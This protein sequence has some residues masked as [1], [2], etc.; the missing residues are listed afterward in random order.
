MTAA[1]TWMTMVALMEEV[2]FSFLHS[3]MSE[4]IWNIPVHH[5]RHSEM[6]WVYHKNRYITEYL[7]FPESIDVT[8][9][10]KWCQAQQTPP[11]SRYHVHFRSKVKQTDDMTYQGQ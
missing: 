2:F 8:A 3:I 1:M 11:A 5:N 7:L 10:L 4:M 9:K 6:V